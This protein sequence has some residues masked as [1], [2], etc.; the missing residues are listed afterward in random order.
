M[1]TMWFFF[2]V[3]LLLEQFSSP[4]CRT[5]CTCNALS[6]SSAS[7][8]SLYHGHYCWKWFSIPPTK[9]N[10]MLTQ[11]L[12]LNFG[13]FQLPG[14]P[15][16]QCDQTPRTGDLNISV[17]ETFSFISLSLNNSFVC[18]ASAADPLYT[19]KGGGV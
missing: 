8:V 7:K 12:L 10:K 11:F 19:R 14:C 3:H 16:S 18:I 9:I 13:L 2:P 5:V 6:I 15:R 4:T 17:P 1:E